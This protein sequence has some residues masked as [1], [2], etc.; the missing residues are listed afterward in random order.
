MRPNLVG[1]WRYFKSDRI[2]Y[3]AQLIEVGGDVIGQMR[4]M[5]E[6]GGGQLTISSQDIE[7]STD[8]IPANS[9]GEIPIRIPSTKEIY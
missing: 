9:A 7:H 5:Q 8:V 3:V 4:M 6:M 1:A 2:N